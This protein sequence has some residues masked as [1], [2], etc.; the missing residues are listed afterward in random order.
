MHAP[1]PGATPFIAW[2]IRLTSV[3]SAASGLPADSSAQRV[4]YTRALETGAPCSRTSSSIRLTLFLLLP[5]C[6][7]MRS[8]ST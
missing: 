2:R 8:S 7:S 1:K 3:L 5:S 4:L 6:V